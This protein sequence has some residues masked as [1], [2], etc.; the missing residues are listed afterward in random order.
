MFC[1]FCSSIGGS[2]SGSASIKVLFAPCTWN[3]TIVLDV[4]AIVKQIYFKQV[5][6][7]HVIPICNCANIIVIGGSRVFDA[8]I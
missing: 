6:F 2:G 4:S 7:M 5:T 3:C 8:D 1:C